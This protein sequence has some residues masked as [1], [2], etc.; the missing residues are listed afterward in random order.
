MDDNEDMFE[1]NEVSFRLERNAFE[2]LGFENVLGLGGTINLKK[3]G[4]T[5]T[6]K[7]KLIAL[8]TIILINDLFDGEISHIEFNNKNYGFKDP[9][10]KYILDL[11]ENLPDFKYKNPSAYIFGYIPVFKRFDGSKS[12]KGKR[13]IDKEA[14][15][16]SYNIYEKIE[17]GLSV[18]FDIVDILRYARLC[19][20]L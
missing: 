13:S 6:E 7:F 16:D 9:E 8:A 5:D 3:S 18:K 19:L 12:I 20:N 14:L 1:E 2:R 17:P 11:S 15:Q 4:Y 10:I